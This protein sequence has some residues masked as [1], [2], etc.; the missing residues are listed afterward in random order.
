MKIEEQM[1]ISAVRY[2]IGRQ[3]YIVSDTCNFVKDIKEKLSVNCLNIIIKDIE[4]TIE[5]YHRA[6][7]TCSMEMDERCWA[8]LL[9]ILKGYVNDTR[10]SN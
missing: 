5:M 2:A 9:N 10:T 3:S 6:N 7:I 1:L 8:N 4:E